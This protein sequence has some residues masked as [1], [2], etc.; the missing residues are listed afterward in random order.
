M[1][2]SPI[3]GD[4][5]TPHNQVKEEIA[6]KSNQ[7]A[8][9]SRTPKTMCKMRET[10]LIGA[11]QQRPRILWDLRHSEGPNTDNKGI[12]ADGEEDDQILL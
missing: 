8:A 4:R 3:G 6:P 12:Q 11:T 1:K 2:K 9:V 10:T 5:G 7:G